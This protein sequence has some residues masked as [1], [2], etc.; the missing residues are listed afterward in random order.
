M[1]EESERGIRNLDGSGSDERKKP[2]HVR[3]LNFG[4]SIL[5]LHVVRQFHNQRDG[6]LTIDRNVAMIPCTS[7]GEFVRNWIETHRGAI[8]DTDESAIL[9]PVLGLQPAKRRIAQSP[10]LCNQRKRVKRKGSSVKICRAKR[11]SISEN[12][13][14]ENVRR[15]L[16]RTES[17]DREQGHVTASPVLV[18]YKSGNKRCN[19]ERKVLHRI[20]NKRPETTENFCN[21]EATTSPGFRSNSYQWKQRLDGLSDAFASSEED[22]GS[23]LLIDTRQLHALAKKLKDSFEHLDDADCVASNHSEDC[24]ISKSLNISG[25]SKD[26]QASVIAGTLKNSKISDHSQIS[27]HS[28]ISDHPEIVEDSK[29]FEDSKISE[30]STGSDPPEKRLSI[31]SFVDARDTAG[32][33]IESIAEDLEDPRDVIKLTTDGNDNE[34]SVRIEDA[35]TQDTDLSVPVHPRVYVNNPLS[36]ICSNSMS[37]RT[38][39]S[40]RTYFSK[41]EQIGYPVAYQSQKISEDSSHSTVG[42]GNKSVESGVIVNAESPQRPQSDPIVYF[43]LMDSIEKRKRKPKKGS[44][45]EKLQTAVSRQMSFLKMWRHQMKQAPNGNASLPS[46]F[47]RVRICSS[48]FN[49][50]FLEGTAIKDPFNLLPRTEGSRFPRRIR[51]MTVP[52]I[53]GKIKSETPSLVQIFPPW[54][55]LDDKELTLNVTYIN[56]VSDDSRIVREDTNDRPARLSVVQEFDCSCIRTGK[57]NT[58]CSERC[59]KPNVIGR[60][61]EVEN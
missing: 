32:M 49:R 41:A 24:R 14:K 23:G 25:N 9:S 5:T 60:L 30:G 27:D 40:D 52:E 15:N 16:F 12:D 51:I 44:L 1:S 10:V 43:N 37:S 6:A 4:Q 17:E 42:L 26:S 2:S 19:S 58:R 20:E 22:T 18:R 50:Q 36:S 13:R 11:R 59:N 33:E 48:S 31:E 46:V 3:R 39:D 34:Y 21:N 28:K 55:T 38:Q 57:M 35:D 8:T 47:V 61:F 45:S 29:A 54:E 56:V 53:V 7:K